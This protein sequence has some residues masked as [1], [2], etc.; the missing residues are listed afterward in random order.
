MLLQI[1]KKLISILLITI[2]SS[3]GFAQS[4]LSTLDSLGNEVSNW[5]TA[6]DSA[7]SLINFYE[8]SEYRNGIDTLKVKY[9]EKECLLVRHI[10][11]RHKT[12][13]EVY[14]KN[15]NLI[16]E[17]F[18]DT[19]EHRLNRAIEKNETGKTIYVYESNN[20]INTSIS[21]YDSGR[22]S[23]INIFDDKENH[24]IYEV[25]YDSTG[26]VDIETN[27]IYK[28]SILHKKSYY[29]HTN[30]KA[31]EYFEGNKP[32]SY[33]EYHLD[34]KIRIKGTILGMP[35]NHVDKWQYY[36][37]NGNL[38]K[39]VFYSKT[40]P[41]YKSGIWKYWDENGKL[42]KQEW[43]ENGELKK[44]KNYLPNKKSSVAN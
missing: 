3:V 27:Y 42:I 44:T 32:T 31:L 36:Y 15:Y 41:N 24:I 43:Y 28:D 22:L 35:I 29:T 18:F 16:S 2:G 14:D 17:N 26:K 38:E 34:G 1:E 10:Y 13:T 40:N 4:S 25:L 9:R 8:K 30:Q 21:Y 6:A 5:N 19:L 7:Y 23:R 20:Q 12:K 39:E 11:N 33:L 37:A